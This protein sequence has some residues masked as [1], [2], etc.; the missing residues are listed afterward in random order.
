MLDKCW[1]RGVYT[2]ENDEKA[3]LFREDKNNVADI[4]VNMGVAELINNKNFNKMCDQMGSVELITDILGN[5][6]TLV[7]RFAH[8]NEQQAQIEANGPAKNNEI[9][10]NDEIG[11]EI[12][13]NNGPQSNT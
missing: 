5:N 10:K 2:E 3:S 7:E 9:V 1:T 8:F 13:G 11:V 4:N 6:T 12:Q